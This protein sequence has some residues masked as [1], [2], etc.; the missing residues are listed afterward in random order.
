MMLRVK[1]EWATSFLPAISASGVPRRKTRSSGRASPLD[2]AACFGAEPSRRD[3][4]V[5]VTG[6]FLPRFPEITVGRDG[7]GRK[8]GVL[9]LGSAGAAKQSRAGHDVAAPSGNRM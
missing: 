3:T 8:A 9:L 5:N 4:P 7:Y 2:H 1:R 6:N